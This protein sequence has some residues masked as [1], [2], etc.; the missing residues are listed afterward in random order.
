M[1]FIIENMR[2][3]DALQT[4]LIEEE[5]F[6]EPWSQ[7]AFEE[8]FENELATILIARDIKSHNVIGFA[9]ARVLCGECYIN[10]IA[11]TASARGKG[12]G[13]ALLSKL[14]ESVKESSEF[15]TLEVRASNEIAQSL[16]KKLGFIQVGIRKNF[17]S[18][19]TEDA[20][21]MTKNLR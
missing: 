1:D 3:E 19:P 16:Y 8:E 7:K 10:N 5:C 11:V 21:L 17:Y 13:K 20:L 12:I 15:I 18:K 14:I 2:F 6:T 9:N 4:S